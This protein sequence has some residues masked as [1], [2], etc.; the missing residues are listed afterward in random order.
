MILELIEYVPGGNPLLGVKTA[1]RFLDISGII[2]ESV[3]GT[4]I[5]SSV[6]PWSLVT[7]TDPSTLK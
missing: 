6:I 4:G 7:A 5:V 3:S 2:E 1:S